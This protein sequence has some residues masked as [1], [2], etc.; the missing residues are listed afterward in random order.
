MSPLQLNEFMSQLSPPP[1]QEMNQADVS[2]ILQQNQN[3]TMSS[4]STL[5]TG[6]GGVSNLPLGGGGT[7]GA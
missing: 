2:D 5:L 3:A 7:L 6:A 1:K 4:G